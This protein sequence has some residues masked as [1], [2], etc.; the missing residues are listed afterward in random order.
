[1]NARTL[2]LAALLAMVAAPL[3]AQTGHPAKGSWSGYWGPSEAAKKRVLL[4]LDWRDNEIVG[5]INPGANAV[6]VEKA[7]LDVD[8]WTLTLDANMPRA[9][10]PATSPRV[11]SRTS[12]RG[13]IARTTLAPIALAMALFSA[14]PN[15]HHSSRISARSWGVR[16][17]VLG[18]R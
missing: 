14:Q 8:T 5:T 3:C 18:I 7:T 16:G 9:A 2:T 1:M 15:A 6:K 17:I 4:L 11:S 10:R 12:A 13:R